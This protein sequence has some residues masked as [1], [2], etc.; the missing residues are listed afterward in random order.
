LPVHRR[1][2][3]ARTATTTAAATATTA[4]TAAVVI[5]AAAAAGRPLLCVH[6]VFTGFPAVWARL[7][8]FELLAC[9][10][11]TTLVLVL[12]LVWARLSP[13]YNLI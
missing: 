11:S 10:L 13:P 5:A 8:V 6:Q 2:G 12:V 9:V 3:V 7:V 1:K 4:T